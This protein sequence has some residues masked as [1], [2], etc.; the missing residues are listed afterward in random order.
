MISSL[1]SFSVGDYSGFLKIKLFNYGLLTKKSILP[2]I[3]NFALASD[4][5]TAATTDMIRDVAPRERRALS[6]MSTVLA[7]MGFL[8]FFKTVV[9]IRISTN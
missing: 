9:R 4:T 8:S 1:H 3:K 2:F 6:M 7:Y 5:A